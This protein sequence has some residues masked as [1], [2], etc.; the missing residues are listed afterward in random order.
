MTLRMAGFFIS[1]DHH[2]PYHGYEISISI[3]ELYEFYLL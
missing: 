1:V 2:N 3:N